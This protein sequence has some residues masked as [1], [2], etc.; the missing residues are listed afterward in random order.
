MDFISKPVISGFTSA[1]S[2]IIILTQLKGVLG[3]RCKCHGI[4]D[5]L[6][7]L[8]TQLNTSQ[9]ADATIGITCMVAL[10]GIKVRFYILFTI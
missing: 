10:I 3:L 6:K 8:T 1:T 4:I 7:C 2:V 9:I 5:N